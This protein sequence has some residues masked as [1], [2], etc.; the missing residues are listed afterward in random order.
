[1]TITSLLLG[2][3]LQMGRPPRV[4]K[5]PL[6]SKAR[7]FVMNFTKSRFDMASKDF[8][9]S[10]RDVVTPSAL[11]EVKQQSDTALG[12][13]QSIVMVR[14]RTSGNLRVVELVCR[15]EKS[16]GAFRVAFDALDS[17]AVLN[18]EPLTNEPVDPVLEG[19]AREWLKNFTAKNLAAA[20]SHFE[21]RLQVE[22]PTSKLAKLQAQVENAYGAF[23]TVKEARQM[24]DEPYRTIELI[25]VY[26][27]ASVSVRI[28]FNSD[29]S[30]TG[31]KLEPIA[32]ENP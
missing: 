20:T 26:D 21:R 2:I 13:F 10:M 32:P 19:I 6:E 17:I 29:A 11:A 1:M 7:D 3:L 5:N 31:I 8:N 9:E 16:L 27:R 4:L 30:I 28:A 23:H 22:M 24:T 25:A 18:L 12:A 15:F 14:Q